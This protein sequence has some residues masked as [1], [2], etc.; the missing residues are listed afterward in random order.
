MLRPH[1]YLQQARRQLQEEKSELL[2]QRQETISLLQ[3]TAIRHTR[4]EEACDGQSVSLFAAKY[5]LDLAVYY[6][7]LSHT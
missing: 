1:R 4:A 3:D 6:I 2:R 7:R 5:Q